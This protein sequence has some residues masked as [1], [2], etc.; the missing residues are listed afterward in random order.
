MLPW[1]TDISNE[2]GY[3][4]KLKSLHSDKR[5][6]EFLNA[7]DTTEDKS[8]GFK[9]ACLSSDCPKDGAVNQYKGITTSY[10]PQVRTYSSR[11]SYTKRF[12][13]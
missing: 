9:K 3:R 7:M 10:K 2:D 12:C 8:A 4:A 13:I 6:K 5:A 1:F 11:T